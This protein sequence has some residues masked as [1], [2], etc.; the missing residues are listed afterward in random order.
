MK[1]LIY[2]VQHPTIKSSRKKE[3]ESKKK[4]ARGEGKRGNERKNEGNGREDTL[5]M[6]D[7]WENGIMK[8]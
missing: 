3:S 2:K 8:Q 1:K 5:L 7:I 6:E 4:E